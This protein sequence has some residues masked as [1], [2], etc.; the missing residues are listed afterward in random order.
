ME[1]ARV[2]WLHLSSSRVPGAATTYTV[3]RSNDPRSGLGGACPT[4]HYASWEILLAKLRHIQVREPI[5]EEAGRELNKSG[6]YLLQ[7]IPL[8]NQQLVALEFPDVMN[9]A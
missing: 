5:I 9:V 3:S 2:Y 6:Y 1:N 8:T 7:D 4:A